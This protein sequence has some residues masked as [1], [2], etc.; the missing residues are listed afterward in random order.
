[1]REQ[2]GKTEGGAFDWAPQWVA[3]VVGKDMATKLCEA[4]KKLAIDAR[5]L[6]FFDHDSWKMVG[7]KNP[8]LR[9]RLLQCQ[10][11]EKVTPTVEKGDSVTRVPKI[12][13]SDEVETLG[14]VNGNDDA[15]GSGFQEYEDQLR[16]YEVCHD[17]LRVQAANSIN[18]A[19]ASG[20]A[21]SPKVSVPGEVD[22]NFG[23]FSGD[24]ATRAEEPCQ[25]H[26][27]DA[28]FSYQHHLDA[29]VFSPIKASD[30]MQEKQ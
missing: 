8:I 17:Q 29:A 4:M 22:E 19:N 25:H 9:C 21:T 6:V 5:L 10:E 12:L 16:E 15:N 30:D 14:R 20:P 2:I 26:L 24:E 11:R 3:E 28:V 23:P 7:V 1:M 27:D 18:K 13:S